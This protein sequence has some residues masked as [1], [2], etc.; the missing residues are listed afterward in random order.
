MWT[1]KRRIAWVLSYCVSYELV[2]FATRLAKR[3]YWYSLQRR[4]HRVGPNSF[5]EYPAVTKGERFIQIGS[6][7]QA[8][9]GLRLEAYDNHLGKTYEPTITI[10][11]NVAVNYWCHIACI[12]SIVIQDD[13][14]I[15]SRVYITDH[16]HGETTKESLRLPPALRPLHSSGPVKIEERVWLGEGVVVLPNVV[17]GR[18]SI[19]GA[20]AVVTRSLPP[21]SIAAGVPARVVRTLD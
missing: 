8:L 20:N 4:F 1:I 18:D 14:L 5:I 13:V 7:F 2:S 15:A 10:G 9:A 6:N 3:V 17:I 16:F 11:N 21:R 12:R 19:V